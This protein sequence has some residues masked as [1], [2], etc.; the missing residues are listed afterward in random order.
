[1]AGAVLAAAGLVAVTPMAQ[2]H[3]A[4]P[5]LSIETRLI[6]E[7]I[8]NVPINLL[9]D[10]ANIPYNEVQA[11]NSVAG[12]LFFGGN[13]WVPSA[14]NLWGID[15]GDPT[16]IAAMTNL[17]A[18]FPELNEGLGGLQYQIEGLLAA[19][20]PVSAACD[21]EGCAPMTPPDVITGSTSLDRTIGFLEA[22]TGQREFGLFDNWFR[23]PLSDLINGY[24]FNGATDPSGPAYGDP[25]FG[26][27][28]GGDNPFEG[29]TVGPDNAM[30][31]DGHTFYLNFFQP[32]ENYFQSLLATPPTDGDIPGTGIEIP[33][34]NEF[35]QSLQ[36]VAASL[37]VAFNPY[38]AGSPA[39]PALCDIPG[40]LTTPALVN[41]LDPDGS[42]PMIQAWL[43]G[44]D[45]T[46][47]FP[48]NNA[49]P[50]QISAGIALL[51]TGIFNL[52]PDQ[53]DEA[54][55]QLDAIN[56][57]LP[58]LAVNA[59]I[60]TDPGYLAFITDPGTEFDPVYGGWNP[61]LVLPDILQLFGIGA[62]ASDV[63]QLIDPAAATDGLDAAMAATSM[64]L[65]TLFAG[66]DPATI[67]VDLETLLGGFDSAAL[68][69]DLA[70]LLEN[71]G[72]T[73]APD[74]ATTLLNVF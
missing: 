1:M 27:P 65:G 30:P 6:D 44:V 35:G 46:G 70:T 67:S 64:D 47:A 26:F 60:L 39:C 59:G 37:I 5:T 61:A 54:I 31:W 50:D 24:T 52:T 57:A 58:A 28:N 48:D 15:P 34:L 68:S 25:V 56:P 20:L 71:L 74:L 2:R 36:S 19:E 41:L 32:F 33:T 14:T 53:L 63:S 38:T 72:A 7:S 29:G 13:W 8:F 4:L 73:L 40:N 9:Y 11:L 55:G 21:A 45:G 22:I 66:F 49:T 10:I 51:Q 3:I 12:S 17:F 69:A 62:G 23:V 42:N 18:P 16:H 43:A